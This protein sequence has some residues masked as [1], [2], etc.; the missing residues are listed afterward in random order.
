ME[1][2][3]TTSGLFFQNMYVLNGEIVFLESEFN[4]IFIKIHML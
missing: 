4:Q 1:N 2:E 3:Q